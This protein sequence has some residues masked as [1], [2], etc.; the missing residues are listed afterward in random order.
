M[1][2]GLKPVKHS[3]YTCKVDKIAKT[4]DAKDSVL[5]MGYIDDPEFTAEHLSAQ[6]KERGVTIGATVIRRHRAGNCWCTRA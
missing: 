1:L 6:L 4:L 2:E 3:Q 5:F